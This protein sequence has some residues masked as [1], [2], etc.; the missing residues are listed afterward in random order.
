MRA[1][2]LRCLRVVGYSHATKPPPPYSGPGVFPGLKAVLPGGPGFA[3]TQGSLN[4]LP[5]GGPLDA[6]PCTNHPLPRPH[7]APRIGSQHT[8]GTALW[9]TLPMAEDN[10]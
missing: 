3:H 7:P 9:L 6:L 2:L 4:T 8:K 10:T 1:A 5:P